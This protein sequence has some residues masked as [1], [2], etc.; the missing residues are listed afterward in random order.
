MAKFRWIFVAALFLL[1][2]APFVLR[3]GQEA[4]AQEPERQITLTVAYTQYEWWLIRWEDNEIQCRFLIDHEGLPTAEEV[5]LYCGAD[6]ADQWQATPP[7][8]VTS[9]AESNQCDGLYLHLVA[10]EPKEREVVVQLPPPVVYVSLEGCD[11]QPPE[12]LCSELPSLKLTAEE[13]LPNER[14]TAIQGTYAGEPFVCEAATC[15][16]PLRPT[17]R[18]GVKVEFW[19]DSSYGDSSERF[20]A[21]VRVIDTGV[22]QAP[23][24]GGYYVDVISSQWRGADIESCA[25]IWEAFPS[26]GAPPTWLSTPN[27]RLLMASD[28]PY[29]YLAGRLI[30]QQLVNADECPNGGLL[31]NGYANACGLEKARPQVDVWQD[32]FDQRLISVAKDTG[33]PAQL[34]KNLFAQESQFWPGVFRVPYEFGLGQL[35][36]NGTDSILLWNDSF[37]EQFCP[38]VLAEDACEGG[39]LHLDSNNQA[40][41]RGALALQARADCAGCPAGIDLTNTDFSVALFAG[42]L[43]ANCEQVGQIVYNASGEIAGDVATYED[44]WRMTVANYHGGPGCLS[45]AAYSAWER[46]GIMT[47]EEVSTHFTDPC[48][49]VVPYVQKITDIQEYLTPAPTVA[50]R[51]PTPTVTLTPT[52]G[53]TATPT[54]TLQPGISATPTPTSEAY[55]LPGT[56][57]STPEGYPGPATPVTYPTP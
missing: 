31:P 20:T 6:L 19:A 48:R 50:T 52:L 15:L 32:Q 14:I 42:M 41:L 46:N 26:I 54:A 22:S 30:A 37:F 12:N 2:L 51:T 35:T 33:V 8:T 18:G 24:G 38:L 34:M 56:A 5:A 29:F 21:Q 40:I 27:D 47:W 23:G 13:P 10:S 3:L 44:L 4:A 45:Y 17:A 49:G 39:Y 11:P 57:T 53:P 16:L 28:K 55:P 36:D 1:A 25:R 43:Q 7:C 9:S